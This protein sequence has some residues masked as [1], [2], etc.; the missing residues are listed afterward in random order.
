MT[1]FLHLFII[2]IC[3]RQRHSGSVGQLYPSVIPRVELLENRTKDNLYDSL[4]G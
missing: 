1:T 2:K 4:V 3:S